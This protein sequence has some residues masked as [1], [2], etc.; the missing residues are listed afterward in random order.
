MKTAVMEQP[1]HVRAKALT[2]HAEAFTHQA[3]YYA[4]MQWVSS[5][6][7]FMLLFLQTLKSGYE[8]E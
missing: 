8:R 4:E 7:R 1:V 2:V 6:S 3:S 5:E